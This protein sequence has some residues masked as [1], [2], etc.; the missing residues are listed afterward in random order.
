MSDDKSIRIGLY[1]EDLAAAQEL[2]RSGR[3]ELQI[4]PQAEILDPLTYI[5]IGAGLVAAVKFTIDL[6]ERIKGGVVID[7]QP[8]AKSVIRRDRAIPYGWA[9]VMA[10]DGKSVKIETHDAPKDAAERLLEDIINGVFKNSDGIAKA[11]K[12]ALGA[13]K[14]EA[15]AATT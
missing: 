4:E 3:V 11:A 12:D 8:S 15:P 13:A 5:L 2:A 6:V 1:E 7:L 9:V 14:V 10:A